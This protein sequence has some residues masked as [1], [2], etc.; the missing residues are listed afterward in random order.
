MFSLLINTQVKAN[1]HVVN[2]SCK[3]KNGVCEIGI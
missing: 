1:D 2:D 3:G